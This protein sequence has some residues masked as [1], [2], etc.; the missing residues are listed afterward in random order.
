M[1]LYQAILESGTSWMLLAK[2]PYEARTVATA[3]GLVPKKEKIKKVF[4][5]TEQWLRKFPTGTRALVQHQLPGQLFF[6]VTTGAAMT[7]ALRETGV[8]FEGSKTDV[9]ERRLVWVLVPWTPK[10]SA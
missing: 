7:K 2:D 5:R 1:Q 3:M 6:R 4:N 9:M 8:V 10:L